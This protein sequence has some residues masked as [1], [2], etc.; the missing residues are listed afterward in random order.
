MGKDLNHTHNLNWWSSLDY[1][2]KKQ[3]YLNYRLSKEDISWRIN[4]FLD[5]SYGLEFIMCKI[6]DLESSNPSDDLMLLDTFVKREILKVDKIILENFQSI[7]EIILQN[8]DELKPIEYLSKLKLVYFDNCKIHNVNSLSNINELRVYETPEH[9]T[10]TPSLYHNSEYFNTNVR[11]IKNPFEEVQEY[12][13]G[14][15]KA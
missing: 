4:A 12:F 13:K 2:W 11:I 9:P 10:N 6:F 1:N 7:E 8:V 3:I 15:T 5:D 14:K